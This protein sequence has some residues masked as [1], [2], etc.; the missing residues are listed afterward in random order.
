MRKGRLYNTGKIVTGSKVFISYKGEEFYG[1]VIAIDEK[2]NYF[3]DIE[4]RPGVSLKH[5]SDFVRRNVDARS[6]N[7]P[8]GKMFTEGNHTYVTLFKPPTLEKVDLIKAV[9]K[10]EIQMELDREP[11]RRTIR[12][13]RSFG[14]PVFASNEVF[15][16]LVG[17]YLEEDWAEPCLKLVENVAVIM[18]ETVKEVLDHE[19][20]LKS[21]ERFKALLDERISH[22]INVLKK[23]A[24]EEVLNFV[25]REKVPYTQNHYLNETLAKRRNDRFLQLVC[26]A[27]ESV[28]GEMS[29]TEIQTLLHDLTSRMEMKSI[30]QHMEEDMEDALRAYGKVAFKRFIDGV[31]MICGDAMLQLPQK[32]RLGLS[33]ISDVELERVLSLSS[34]VLER[35][36][37][38][39][40]MV[41]ELDK[42]LKIL[43]DL[44]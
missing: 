9:P 16:K 8:V 33:S 11:L 29:K 30:E 21:S 38:L 17:M 24:L 39:E 42:G 37:S 41:Q 7:H 3:F 36:K 1:K 25:R 19:P 44:R 14:V 26:S 23:Q 4:S 40:L 13:N 35:R 18:E 10:S 2:E 27:L 43:D 12:L 20:L 6:V 28:K 32:A 15:E 34:S 31:P 5:E 22:E